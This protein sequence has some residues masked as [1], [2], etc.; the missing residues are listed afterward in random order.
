MA[1]VAR[2][3]PARWRR[4]WAWGAVVGIAAGVV[5]WVLFATTVFAVREVV[6]TGAH[7]VAPAQ[8]REVAAVPPGT[9]L[10]AV[11]TDAVRGRVRALP[12]VADVVVDRSWPGALVIAVTERSPVAAVAIHGGFVVLDRSGV[13]FNQVRARPGGVVLVRLAHPGPSD[14]ATQAA[15]RVVASLTE[16][17]RDRVAEVLVP[18]STEIQLK[19]TDG[20]TV[21]WGDVDQSETKARVVTALL[22]RGGRT[23]DVSAPEV[24][25]VRSRRWATAN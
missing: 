3:F 17:L 23:I 11:D 18:A 16:P 19:L 6:V 9:P 10:A 21:V 25:A 4:W 5:G 8:V 24:V 20:R 12:A 2:R 22:G 15:L 7:I 13:V 1:R 14:S